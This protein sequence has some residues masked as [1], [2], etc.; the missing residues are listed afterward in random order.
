MPRE[1]GRCAARS[2]SASNSSTRPELWSLCEQERG[3]QAESE[4]GVLPAAR[5]DDLLRRYGLAARCRDF[6]PGVP[7][8][9]RRL[10]TWHRRCS[11]VQARA[12][13]MTADSAHDNGPPR[14]RPPARYPSSA[15]LD[16]T[17][18]SRAALSLTVATK[19]TAVE[20]TIFPWGRAR[21]GV[22][23]RIWAEDRRREGPCGWSCLTP[24]EGGLHDLGTR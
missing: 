8:S 11:A 10:T 22:V 17:G 6:H 24:G 15:G 9:A 1:P 2:R 14:R 4:F 21:G 16:A 13:A 3:R 5:P 19:W 12:W 7:A 23:L 18:L 20:L